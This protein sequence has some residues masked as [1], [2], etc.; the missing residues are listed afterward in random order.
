[1]NGCGV[2]AAP[3]LASLVLRQIERTAR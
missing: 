3:M 1:L 2:D